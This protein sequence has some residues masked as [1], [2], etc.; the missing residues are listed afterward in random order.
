MIFQTHDD[1]LKMGAA[2]GLCFVP[3]RHGWLKSAAWRMVSYIL[4]LIFSKKEKKELL[5]SHSTI[6]NQATCEPGL[7]LGRFAL[8][9][10]WQHIVIEPQKFGTTGGARAGTR[11]VRWDLDRENH[12]LNIAWIADSVDQTL[13]RVS[14]MKIENNG[15]A[16]V[17]FL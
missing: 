17:D 12:P 16:R 10:A 7:R 11:Y 1:F 6:I 4:V 5:F 13:A 15:Q 8:F 14:R 2:P 3:T 9:E